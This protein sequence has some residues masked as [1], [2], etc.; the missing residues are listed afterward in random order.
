MLS[1]LKP[2]VVLSVN[3]EN[4]FTNTDKSV[5]GKYLPIFGSGY[6]GKARIFKFFF[7]KLIIRKLHMVAA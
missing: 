5:I 1:S 3:I 7:P 4:M 2:N 6:S